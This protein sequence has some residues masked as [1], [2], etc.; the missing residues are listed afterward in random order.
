MNILLVDDDLELCELLK[1]YLERE[2]FQITL[3]HDARRG[4]EEALTGK[5]QA[6]ILDV[7][8]PGGNGVDI[9]RAIRQRS[10]LPVLMLTAK[11][12]EMDR[13]QGLE[14][15]AD[16]YMPKPANPRELAA[17]LRSILRRN[18]SADV[19]DSNIKLDELLINLDQHQVSREGDVLDLTATEF[20]ILCVLAREAGK[21]VEKNRLAEQSMQ[22]S[23]TLYDR[24]LD[25]HLSNLRKKLGPNRH[26]DQRI[27]TVRGIGYIYA[28]EQGENAA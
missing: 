25:M 2:L 23:L 17:R 9:L 8:L 26:G 1:R 28:P 12:D 14:I 22:R 11:G 19:A 7:M 4:L 3:V 21:V 13:I 18:R 16:D 20:N 6:V 5:Y 27:K 24:S 10:D 15:G